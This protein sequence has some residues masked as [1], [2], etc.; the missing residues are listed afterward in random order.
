LSL[1]EVDQI[2]WIKKKTWMIEYFKK[3][4]KMLE[5]VCWNYTFLRLT[6]APLGE[7]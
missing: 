5:E 2:G 3:K 6:I 4:T 1:K 7:Q